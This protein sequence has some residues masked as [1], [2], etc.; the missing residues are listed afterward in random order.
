MFFEAISRSVWELNGDQEEGADDI[1]ISMKHTK[2]NMSKKHAPLGFNIN[3]AEEKTVITIINPNKIDGLVERA[4]AN[5]KILKC[6]TDRPMTM[7]ELVNN[8]GEKQANIYMA[9]SRLKKA[10][11]IIKNGNVWGLLSNE[12]NN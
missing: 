3:F 7:E 2:S 12:S 5:T 9:L 8:T 4:G 10:N 6:L 11:K 1:N